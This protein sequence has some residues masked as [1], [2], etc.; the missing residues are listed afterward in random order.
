[1]NLFER[2]NY[3]S[4]PSTEINLLPK[5]SQFVKSSQNG[6]PVICLQML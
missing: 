1:M 2:N 6:T 5:N 4:H 3:D